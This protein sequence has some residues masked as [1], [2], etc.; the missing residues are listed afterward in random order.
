MTR[1][2]TVHTETRGDGFTIELAL[3]PEDMAPD[4]D[5]ESEEDRQETLRKIDSGVWLWFVAR[6][7]VSKHGVRLGVDYL[8]G[9]CYESVED[10]MSTD[11]YYPDMVDQAMEEA[12]STLRKLC[13]E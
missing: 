8:G 6:V 4:W 12:Q 13:S 5:F 10:F 2:E 9:C 3:A 7:T 1:F 11:G